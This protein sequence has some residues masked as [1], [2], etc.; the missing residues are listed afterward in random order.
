MIK[1]KNI[2]QKEQLLSK[3]ESLTEIPMLILVLVMI[4][5]LIIPL[6]VSLPESTHQVLEIIDWVIWAIFALELSIRTYLAPKR[7][8]YLRKNWVDVI[9]VALPLLRIF[10]VLR[11]ARLL[12]I[13][14]FVRVLALFGKFTTEIKTILSRHHLHYLLVVLIGLIGIGSVLIY[15]FD[16]GVA[17]GN[18]SLV[19]SIWMVIVNAF[20]GGYA[21]IYPAGP[22][23]RGISIFLILFGTVLVSYFT[24]SLASYFTEKE[25]DIEQLRIEKKLDN[26]IMEVKKLQQTKKRKKRDIIRR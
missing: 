17:G 26:L 19:D 7:L 2:K 5:T 8:S 22:E 24:A 10:R 25:Q 12:R 20:S 13:L 21:N 16:Q 23:A 4:A 14:R 18:E 15:H 9:V 11:A 6:V 3:F 1:L